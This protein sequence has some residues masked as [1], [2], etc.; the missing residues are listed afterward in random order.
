M[1]KVFL[2]INSFDAL[3]KKPGDV[4]RC[5]YSTIENRAG[6]LYIVGSRKKCTHPDADKIDAVLATWLSH[7]SVYGD[8]F[9]VIHRS[10]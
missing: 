6:K 3:E 9:E 5:T 1:N 2:K 10:S 7:C 8:K 4:V